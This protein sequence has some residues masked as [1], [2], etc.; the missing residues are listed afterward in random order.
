MV[1]VFHF[2]GVPSP[3]IKRETKEPN[4]SSGNIYEMKYNSDR[5]DMV[6]RWERERADISKLWALSPCF[7]QHAVFFLFV[8]IL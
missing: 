6:V 2:G 1:C 5:E 3:L 8:G 7:L 4:H